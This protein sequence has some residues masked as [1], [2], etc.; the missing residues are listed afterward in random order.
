VAY[1]SKDTPMLLYL[2]T[3]AALEQMRKQAEKDNE[4]GPRV[5]VVGPTDVG[6]STVCRLLLS[7]A[8]RVGRRPTF[9]ELDVGQS[10]VSV[11]GT[12]SALC[13]ERPA[14][15]EE[16]FSVQAPLVYHFGSTTP[17]TNIKLYNK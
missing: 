1:V 14:D 2:N 3:H 16:G 11:P 8:V 15:V 5:M 9:V 17:G 6:K 4:R 10:G 13:I 7:Y 12:V